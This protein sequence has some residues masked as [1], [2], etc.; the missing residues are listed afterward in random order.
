[1]CFL[2]VGRPGRMLQVS[3]LQTGTHVISLTAT[4]SYATTTTAHVAVMVGLSPY[5]TYLP[6]VQT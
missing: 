6:I 3:T 4:D 5:Q 1:M 2:T